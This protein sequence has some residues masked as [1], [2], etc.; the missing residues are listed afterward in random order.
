VSNRDRKPCTVVQLR[1][2]QRPYSE[3]L[4]RKDLDPARGVLTMLALS[5]AL[6]VLAFLLALFVM[7]AAGCSR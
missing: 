1:T 5:I 2:W 3:R 6:Y 4:R 7:P